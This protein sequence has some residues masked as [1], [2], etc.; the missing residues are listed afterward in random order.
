MVLP[1]TANLHDALD[2]TRDYL[3]SSQ[4][5]DGTWQGLVESDPR[6]TAFYLN[7]IRN[8]GRAPD[9]ETEAMERYLFSEQLEC[10]AW[11]AWPRGGPDIDVTAVCVLAL[12]RAGTEHGNNARMLG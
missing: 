5:P 12:E 7:T 8:L 11:Q 3:L 1:S 10:G 4:Q 2:R 9:A 6:P